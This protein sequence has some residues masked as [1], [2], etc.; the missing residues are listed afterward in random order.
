[1]ITEIKEKHCSVALDYNQQS[2]N[3]KKK[4]QFEKPDGTLIE[5]GDET[6]GTAELLFQPSLAGKTYRFPGP[7]EADDPTR[8]RGVHELIRDAMLACPSPIRSNMNSLILCGGMSLL[9]GTPERLKKEIFNFFETP[10]KDLSKDKTNLFSK[11]PLDLHKTMINQYFPLNKFVCL[12]PNER[13]Y[14]CW[15]GGSIVGSMSSYQIK[16]FTAND[17]NEMRDCSKITRW[18]Y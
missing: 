16:C 9:P 8:A 17:Y 4:V 11:I 14:L 1:M 13:K 10:L 12:P 18:F 5:L 2:S 7:E 6:F 15:I 3:E